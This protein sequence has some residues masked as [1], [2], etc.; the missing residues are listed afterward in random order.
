MEQ[1][2]KHLLGLLIFV[3]IVIVT[4]PIYRGPLFNVSLDAELKLKKCEACISIESYFTLIGSEYSLIL[5]LIFCYFFFPLSKTLAAAV[6]MLTSNYMNSVLKIIIQ[7]PRPWFENSNLYVNCEAGYGNPSGHMMSGFATFFS[8]AELFIDKYKPI[9]KI[10]ALIYVC[11]GIFVGNI[12]LSRIFLGFHSINQII[13][14]FLLGFSVYYFY[15]HYM[16][17]HQ[18]DPRTLFNEIKN[19]K[20]G[21]IFTIII[22]VLL[23]LVPIASV[24]F[25]DEES[26]KYKAYYDAI[27]KGCSNVKI[28]YYR[29]LN[30]EGIYGG[31]TMS[32]FIGM[33]FGLYYLSFKCSSLH[34]GKEKYINDFFRESNQGWKGNL[35][36]IGISLC[37]MLPMILF[38]IIPNT[39]NFAVIYLFKVSV[40]LF[41]TTM[42][43]FGGVPFA[44]IHFELANKNIYREI[45]EDNTGEN[46]NNQIRVDVNYSNINNDLNQ[47]D[48]NDN[49]T[50]KLNKKKDNKNE[51]TNTNDI[52]QI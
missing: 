19:L 50:D 36:M 5:L 22:L 3:A 52:N 20:Y 47:L 45:Q 31:M 39:A 7:N 40:P 26:E 46:V 35:K 25:V 27:I 38:S 24:I 2:R 49:E 15:F 48:E 11:T 10:E 42:L 17:L 34:P 12:G 18:K 28:K 41:I 1:N 29:I 4:E 16:K 23:F 43:L 37:G 14:G 32:S 44:S 9:P 30:Y 8:V 6:T 51:L 33:Y 13:Y 21:I